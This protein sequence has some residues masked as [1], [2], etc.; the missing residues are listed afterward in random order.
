MNYKREPHWAV[1]LKK[2]YALQDIKPFIGY[3]T[4]AWEQAQRD[5][6]PDASYR[7]LVERA[8][9]LRRQYVRASVTL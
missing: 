2:W 3:D 5:L 8:H 6:G 9:Q 7:T 4:Q 1:T